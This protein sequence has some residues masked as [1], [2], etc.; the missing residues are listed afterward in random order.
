MRVQ[1]PPGATPQQQNRTSH[2]MF[3]AYNPTPS[4]QYT[5]DASRAAA[6]LPDERNGR[7][8]LVLA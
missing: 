2:T 1:L 7:F 8:V 3:D 5:E 6:Q 4:A